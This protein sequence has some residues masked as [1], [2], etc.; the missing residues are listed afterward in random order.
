[1]QANLNLSIGEATA[2]FKNI[3]DDTNNDLTKG[4]AIYKVLSMP[5]HNGIT[6]QDYWNALH[7]LWCKHYEPVR[8]PIIGEESEDCEE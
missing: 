2:I 8:L 5:T 6:K 3:K 4:W 1:M 7:W